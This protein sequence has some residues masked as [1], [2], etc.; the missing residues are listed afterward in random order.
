MKIKALVVDNNPVLLKAVSTLLEQEGC[1]VLTAENGLEAIDIARSE[2]PDIIFTDLI[3]PLVGGEQLCKV[4][5]SSNALK[6][7][8]LVILSAVVHA[9]RDRILA[10]IDYDV[11]IAKGGLKE[12][13]QHLQEA[14]TKYKQKD[15]SPKTFL[16]DASEPPGEDRDLTNLAR[17]LL[18]EKH[19]LKE[20]LENL[21]EGIVELSKQGKIVSIN[22]AAS[23]VLNT[24][25][26]KLIGV[27]ISDI[28]WKTH[29]NDIRLWSEIELTK[30][31]GETLEITEK[32]PLQFNSSIL[33]AYFLP[34][35]RK[36][37][38]FAVCIL[39]DITRQYLAEKE[40]LDF[41]NALH[42][43]NK[44]EAMSCMAGGV[45]HDFNNLLT[46]ICGNLDMISLKKEPSCRDDNIQ[47]IENAKNA[48]HQTVELVRK[49]SCFSPFGIIARENTSID[50][51][52]ENIVNNFKIN[53]DIPDISFQKLGE[54]KYV[55]IDAQQIQTAIENVLQNA[56]EASRNKGIHISIHNDLVAEATVLA[57]QYIDSGDYVK[58]CIA[59][60]G[61]GIHLENLHDI[62]DP[63][64]S[65]KQRGTTKGMGL[66][67][68]IVYQTFRNHGG[69]VVVESEANQG[70]SVSLYIPT[71]IVL[72]PSYP[73]DVERQTKVLLC[74]DDD[75]LR[76]ISK[77]MLEYLG[78][79]AFEARNKE[80]ALQIILQN[81][82]KQI[83]ISVAV[84]N[85]IG[86]GKRSGIDT[87][88]ELH[89]LD[90]ELKVIISSG[91]IQDPTMI[92]YH[93]YGFCNS[94]YKP[95]TLDDL[96]KVLASI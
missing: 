33:T 41:E 56:L 45:A 35:Q 71:H 50:N 82:T 77:I 81:K 70:T 69:Y 94:L 89:E 83:K 26:E 34:I 18:S 95:Y 87:C 84:I 48:A 23:S 90:K 32:E 67:L 66:G 85:L 79:N 1:L 92:H 5:R 13:R 55:N 60:R 24:T 91:L 39:R 72:P 65:T 9:E 7:T 73:S 27:H 3:M 54:D 75:Q 38:S 42:L 47:L 2:I 63:Y 51:L 8:F 19:H 58:I 15:S 46:A 4:I 57:G 93:E 20:M 43:V 29:A 6:N 96:K 21:N 31:G 25:L 28:S 14:L 17:E 88:K 36:D 22:K 49:I 10:E 78:Y 11:C 37:T 61:R 44:M 86:D 30:S 59:D 12:L 62:F 80:E 76:F 64:Y 16:G 68:T 52:V 40:K 74:E 53:N